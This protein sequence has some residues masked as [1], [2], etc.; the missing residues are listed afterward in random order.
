[1]PE[2]R[3]NG[4]GNNIRAIADYSVPLQIRAFANSIPINVI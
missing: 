3:G 2:S 4:E 1:M